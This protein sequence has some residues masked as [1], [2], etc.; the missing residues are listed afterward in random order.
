[1]V[2]DQT[3]PSLANEGPG[4]QPAL[5]QTLSGLPLYGQNKMQ[6][7]LTPYVEEGQVSIMPHNPLA[8][9]Q[10]TAHSKPPVQPRIPLQHYPTNQVV[11]I[12]TMSGQSNLVLPS[13]RPPSGVG[14]PIRPPIQPTSSTALNQQMQ[15]SLPHSVHVGRS[16]GAHNFQMVRPDTSFQVP[17]I[18]CIFMFE[19]CIDVSIFTKLS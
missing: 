12:G 11:Q 13:V 19:C 9:N 2:S 18:S 1:M 5:L 14:L 17:H 7:G 3:S 8:P 10:L 4:G 15:G 16:T 6:S